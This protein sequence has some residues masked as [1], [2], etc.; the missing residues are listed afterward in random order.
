MPRESR[1]KEWRILLSGELRERRVTDGNPRVQYAGYIF[2]PTG[3]GTAA[4]AYIHALDCVG[5]ELSVANR[6]KRTDR[7]VVDPLIISLLDRPLAAQLHICNSEPLDALAFASIARRLI[8]QT[9]W[10][11]DRLPEKSVA[12][13]R[14]VLEVWVPSSYN[15]EVFRQQI[16]APVF[17]LPHPVYTREVGPEVVAALNRGL[18]LKESDFLFVSVATWQERKNLP[19]VI[20]AFLRAFPDE[21]DAVLAIKTR[22]EFVHQRVALAQIDEAM[23][24]AGAAHGPAVRSRIRI[25]DG[26]WNE[27][28]LTALMQRADCYVSL[29]RGEGWCYPLFDTACRGI[30]VVSTGYSGPMDYLDARYHQ[31]VKYELTTPDMERKPGWSPFT[32]NM[33]W[34]APDVED[35]ARKMRMI[36]DDRTEALE[37]ARAGAAALQQR[38][39]AQAVGEMARERL[40]ELVNKLDG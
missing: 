18:N 2:A 22:F 35:A 38:F 4:R 9:A 10:E 34:A 23:K 30:P 17:Q 20:E 37:K 26:I 16:D 33:Q 39:S 6:S 27:E 28:A 8:M 13:L 12:A 3:Y 11:A 15:A 32:A 31:L 25:C 29:H 40:M 5:I 24:R 7:M 14:D 19:E 21:R 1:A 36:Y